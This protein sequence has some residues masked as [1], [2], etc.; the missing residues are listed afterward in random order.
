MGS[1]AVLGAAEPL[2][3][4][5]II[6]Q[7]S[8]TPIDAW[9]DLE[10]DPVSARPL[11]ARSAPGP[12]AWLWARWLAAHWHTESGAAPASW[13]VLSEAS[14]GLQDALAVVDT[15]FAFG[16]S[17]PPQCAADPNHNSAPHSSRLPPA[18]RCLSGGPK[19]PGL[20]PSL[21]PNSLPAI[22]LYPWHSSQPL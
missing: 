1:E 22:F 8:T 7:T 15:A 4:E 5:A 9:Y 16:P 3:V 21:H 19:A 13:N 2:S 14:R 20:S 10:P 11:P 17:T 12:C 18:G 6:S